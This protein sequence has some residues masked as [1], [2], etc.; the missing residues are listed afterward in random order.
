MIEQVVAGVLTSFGGAL[1]ERFANGR[2]ESVE[3]QPIARDVRELMATQERTEVA[4][5]ELTALFRDV[6]EH[7]D[8]L[9]WS[10]GKLRTRTSVR[11]EP[12]EAAPTLGDALINLD[13]Y[14][15]E[16]Q[17]RGEP[18]PP[19]DPQEPAPP[20]EPALPL[21]TAPPEPTAPTDPPAPPAGESGA[22][23][24]T[25]TLFAEIDR[26]IQRRRSGNAEGEPSS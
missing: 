14:I 3:V 2:G 16:L 11:F 20:L 7:I 8:G 23:P 4:V 24:E 25:Q 26:D 5:K 21:E 1:A 22:M 12:T 19:G 13:R 6:I 10:Q 17:A 9:V 15:R 18:T